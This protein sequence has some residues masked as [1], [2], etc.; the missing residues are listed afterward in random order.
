MAGFSAEFGSTSCRDLTG[1]DMMSDHDAF[2]DSA[3]W[4][5]D[6]MRQIEFTVARMAALADPEVWEAEVERVAPPE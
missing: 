3:V 2:L 1:Y 6:C 5:T 4:R